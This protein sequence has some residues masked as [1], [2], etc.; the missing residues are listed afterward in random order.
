[1]QLKY[2]EDK[3]QFMLR[4]Q[5]RAAGQKGAVKAAL[6]TRKGASKLDEKAEQAARVD[7]RQPAGESWNDNKHCR[8]K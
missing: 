4:Q 1:L 7:D 6:R 2:K 5:A 8:P 3:R